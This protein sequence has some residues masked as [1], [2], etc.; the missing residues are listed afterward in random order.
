MRRDAGAGGFGFSFDVF[1]YLSKTSLDVSEIEGKECIKGSVHGLPDDE[2][3]KENIRRMNA[4][5]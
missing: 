1:R 4:E 5:V 2:D 3:V